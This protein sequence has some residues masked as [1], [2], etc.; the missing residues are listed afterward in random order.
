M[1]LI[2]N[3]VSPVTIFS[4]LTM[5]KG[6]ASLLMTL[7][8]YE[9]TKSLVEPTSLLVLLLITPTIL[10]VTELSLDGEELAVSHRIQRHRFLV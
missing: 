5:V 6:L 3:C 9:P 1:Q 4:I 7:L 8:S 10:V 2:V